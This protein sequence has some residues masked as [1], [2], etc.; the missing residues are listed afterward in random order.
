MKSRRCIEINVEGK[1]HSRAC[2]LLQAALFERAGRWWSQAKLTGR[3][4]PQM[5]QELASFISNRVHIIVPGVG[6]TPNNDCTRSIRHAL[7]RSG[8]RRPGHDCMAKLHHPPFKLPAKTT[9]GTP[10]S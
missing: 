9:E 1:A 2:R 3:V 5:G 4:G 6:H 8:A 7:F 10:A